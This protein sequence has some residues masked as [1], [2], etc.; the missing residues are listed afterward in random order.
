[1]KR[2]IKSVVSKASDENDIEVRQEIAEDPKTPLSTL[3]DL[4][5]NSSMFYARARVAL[6]PKTPADVLWKL[7]HQNIDDVAD[8]YIWVAM[9]RGNP[10][11]PLDLQREL[12]RRLRNSNVEWIYNDLIYDRLPNYSKGEE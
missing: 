9:Y 5:L 8:K 11:T 6:D 10:R 4:A 12:S 3:I 1:M 7:Y 2:Y